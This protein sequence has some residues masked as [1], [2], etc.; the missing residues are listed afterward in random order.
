MCLVIATPRI[1]VETAV[2]AIRFRKESP[3]TGKRNDKG[4]E[5]KL[6]IRPSYEEGCN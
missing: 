5:S 1:A 6:R 4:G 3:I 2:T